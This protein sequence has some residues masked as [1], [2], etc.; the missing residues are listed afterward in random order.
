[1]VSWRS[2]TVLGLRDN[3]SCSRRPLS[4]GSQKIISRTSSWTSSMKRLGVEE[5]EEDIPAEL[6]RRESR[7]ARIREAKAALEQDAA[8]A[9]AEKL[10]RQAEE[11]QSKA[12]DAL[13]DRVEQKRARTRAEKA[14]AQADQLEP[15]PDPTERNDGWPHHRVPANVD[16]TPRPHAQRNFTD[17]D[18]RI[19]LKDGAYL[20]AYN[21]QVV[22]DEHAQVIVAEGVSN[23]APDQQRSLASECETSCKRATARRSTPAGRVSSNRRS[24]RSKGHEDSAGSRNAPSSRYE[25]RDARLPHPQPAQA[26]PIEARDRRERLTQGSHLQIGTRTGTGTRTGVA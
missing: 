24:D 16:G 18:S 25:P 19:V 10:R 1:M 7:L 21:A 26:L 2:N 14:R 5:T 3:R 17:S 22:V 11:Q 8:R 6:A 20:Q 9:R 4:S 15:S 12:D 13:V 23:Q